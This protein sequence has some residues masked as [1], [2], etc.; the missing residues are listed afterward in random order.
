MN[1]SVVYRGLPMAMLNLGG[2]TAVQFWF[3]GFF[4][5]ALTPAGEKVSSTN[6]IG[7]NA[8]S[9]CSGS[10]RACT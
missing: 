3:T 8:Q 1:P 5:R 9:R 10:G 7:A 4:Q 6:Q 2:C